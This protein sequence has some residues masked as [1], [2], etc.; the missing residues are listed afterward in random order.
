[1]VRSSYTRHMQQDNDK[2][3]KIQQWPM[4]TVHQNAHNRFT[5]RRVPSIE[6][7]HF[8]NIRPHEHD[9]NHSNGQQ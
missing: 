5:T 9:R 6:R 1:M 3:S 2:F 7:D 8:A 4:H